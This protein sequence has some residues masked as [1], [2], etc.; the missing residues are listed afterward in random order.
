M[1]AEFGSFD[2]WIVHHED[3]D[4]D[5]HEGPFDADQ[6]KGAALAAFDECIANGES[7]VVT[8]IPLEDTK[9]D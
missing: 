7:C 1:L 3:S 6:A 8:L 5:I 4:H 2:M 9:S